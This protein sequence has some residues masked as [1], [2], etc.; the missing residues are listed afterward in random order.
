M[1][2]RDSI[3]SEDAEEI[4]LEDVV[5]NVSDPIVQW[6]KEAQS[7]EDTQGLGEVQPSG[8][9][10]EP[11]EVQLSEGV[12]EPEEE[13]LI[14]SAVELESRYFS[15]QEDTLQLLMA[16]DKPT[17]ELKCNVPVTFTMTPVNGSGA[18]G[19][20][21]EFN[22]QQKPRYMFLVNTV[23]MK[24]ET[25]GEYTSLVD[26]T[27]CKY[28]ESNQFSFTFVSPGDYYI[29]G[30][31][32]DFGTMPLKTADSERYYFTISDEA[33]PSLD[34]VADGIVEECLAAGCSTDYE[35]A[36]YFHDWIISHSEYD[37]SGIYMGADGVLLRGKGTCESYYRALDLLLG[38]VGIP[39]ERAEGNGHVW[40]CVRLDGEWT[41]IDA[42]WNGGKYS[43]SMAYMNHL[44]F[45]VT[46]EM[47]KKV[48]SDHKPVNSRPCT[49]YERNY[50]IRSGEISRWTDPLEE[51]LREKLAAGETAFTI[52]AEYNAY[53]SVYHIIYPM[54]AYALDQKLYGER[55][56]RVAYDSENKR[57][58]VSPFTE[59][60]SG[61]TGGGT[62]TGSGST[63]G[64]TGTGSGSA[65][66]ST[67]TGSGST[68]GSTGTGSGSNGGGT[69]T[70]SGNTGGS[71]GEG[72]GSTGGSTGTGS[73]STG[74]TS[75][76]A[77]GHSFTAGWKQT[78][79]PTCTK[80]GKKR[81]TCSVCGAVEEKSVPMTS[82]HTTQNLANGKKRTICTVCKKVLSEQKVQVKLNVTTLPLQVKKSTKVLKVA[83]KDKE[84]KVVYWSSSNQK[85]VQVN[86][87][88]GKITAKKAGKAYV[89]VT[90]KSG[91]SARCLIKVQNKK[92]SVSKLKVSPTKVSLKKGQ[93]QKIKT[94][95]TPLTATDKVRYS[96]SNKK[97]ASV[98]AKGVI[99]AKKKGK[100]KITVRAGSKKATITVTVR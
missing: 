76:C 32:M 9:V 70:G 40:S 30:Y 59:E 84:D 93:K 94:S 53:P 46:D 60:G 77:L 44:Y 23:M 38:K 18:M 73:G 83:S 72:S 69:G 95:I 42:T 24:D 78:V 35:K 96:S 55:L 64:G 3:W 29:K 4:L 88:S 45:G 37:N 62:G 63:G 49:S 57:F 50:F 92:V 54:A 52:A 82:H 99:T 47:I 68:G 41:Q 34:E 8:S 17:S 7:S 67:G 5:E 65:G 21:V 100:A 58:T 74:S 80:N 71:T 39:S 48:H 91:A 22:G 10:Q 79:A 14:E 66:G 75:G 61:S 13:L 19:D 51:T 15:A 20:V 90:M 1:C 97:V 12:Q 33:T 87:K 2:I 98:S 11:E 43:E 25:T 26:P 85:I 6:A 89:I 81:R 31:V 27:K 56:C 36:L 86:K 28:V 16:P